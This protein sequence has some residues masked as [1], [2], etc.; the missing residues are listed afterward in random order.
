MLLT[1]C[2]KY[3]PPKSPHRAR[4]P[5]HSGL[6]SS[7]DTLQLLGVWSCVCG[8]CLCEVAALSG[9][10]LKGLSILA[11]QH[12]MVCF[13]HSDQPTFQGGIL[14]RSTHHDN[15]PPPIFR[16]EPSR[17]ELSFATRAIRCH[18][19]SFP[20]FLPCQRSLLRLTPGELRNILAACCPT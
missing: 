4:V 12:S 15:I 16:Y 18:L 14:E 19:D 2:N 11:N 17:S 13:G 8:Q 6:A 9:G 1:Y 3:E 10:L 7:K 5:C 20:N